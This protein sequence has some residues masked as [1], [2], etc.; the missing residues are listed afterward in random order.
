M[1]ILKNYKSSLILL[2]AIIIG[3]ALGLLFRED[4]LWIKPLG[5][6]FVNLCFMVVTPLVFFTI[7]S[8]IANIVSL[9]RLGKILRNVCIVCVI[10]GLC[11]SLIMLIVMLII[12]PVGNNTILLD[13]AAQAE[14]LNVGEQI[15]GVLTVSDFPL[16]LSKSHMIPLILFAIFLGIAAGN[17]KEETSQTK[18]LLSECSK[19]MMK[20]VSY[21]MKYAPIG[22]MAYFACLVAEIGP[23]LV[24]SY[25]RSLFIYVPV[26]IL[27]FAV[28]YTIYAYIAKGIPGIKSFWKNMFPAFITSLGTQSSLASLPTNLVCAEK[29]GIEKDVRDITLSMGATMHMEGSCIGAMLKIAFLFTIF[30]RSFTGIDT[31]LIALLI[32]TLSGCVICGVPGGGMV[33][34]LL[35][36]SL[37]N[38]PASAF[39]II[40]AIALIIDAPA[41]ACNVVGDLPTAMLVDRM[42]KPQINID[43]NKE[44]I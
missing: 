23:S 1:K 32:A 26:C 6:I 20:L 29:M 39:P 11:S 27:Y 42:S 9:K 37:Y 31:Y 17:L 38:F 3:I 15:I 43:E 19:I 28:F 18:K 35:I 5:T 4:I 8:S 30:G 41:T 33:G 21:I 12:N 25:A 24:G 44:M 22:M 10:T 36:V 34:E 14:T 2:G 16:L 40:A 7:S 13:T